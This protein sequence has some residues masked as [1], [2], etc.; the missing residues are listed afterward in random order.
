MLSDYV[1]ILF[2]IQ[3][4]PNSFSI[5]Y[6]FLPELIITVIDN[7]RFSSPA[8]RSN[9]WRFSNFII[10]SVFI[11]WHSS[12]RK[13]FL[14]LFVQLFIYLAWIPVLLSG[15]W[16]FTMIYLDAPV[17]PY[18]DS[19]NPFKLFTMSIL[20]V[21]AIPVFLTLWHS[22]IFQLILFFSCPGP[23][24]SHLFKEP[25]FFLVGNGT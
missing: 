4:L 22:K 2:H 18:L 11:S 21:P 10:P 17:S 20:R 5:Y 12:V 14:F 8:Q 7:W 19:K 6:C 15:L 16:S 25:W 3:L 24:I 9:N 1:N 23:E 13:N